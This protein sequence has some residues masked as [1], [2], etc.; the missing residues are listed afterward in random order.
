M[1]RFTIIQV[2]IVLISLFGFTFL[3]AAEENI[4]GEILIQFNNGVNTEKIYSWSENNK[5]IDLQPVRL[6]S[7]RMNVWLFT[8]NSDQKKYT[9]LITSFK[10]NILIKEIQ[11]NHFVTLRETL[12]NDPLFGEQ[13]ALQNTGQN[14]GTADADI[15]ATNAW[16]FVTGGYNALGEEIVIAIIDSGCDLGHDDLDFWKNELEI[17][18]NNIDD[19][20]NGYVDDYDGWNAY[21]HTGQPVSSSHGTHVAGIAGAVGNNSLG[22]SGVNWG[23]KIMPVCG[24]SSSE[25]VVVEAYGYVLEM[26]ARYNETDGAEGAYVVVTNASFGVNNG[27]PANFPIWCAIYDSLGAEGVLSCGATANNNWNID[28]V[29][30]MPTACDSDY[31]ITVTNTTNTDTRNPSAGYGATT[32]D[33]GAPGTSIKSTDTNDS[34]SYKTGTSMATPQVTGAVALMYSAIPANILDAFGNNYSDLAILI[35]NYLLDNVDQIDALADITVSGGRLNVHR[36]IQQFNNRFEVSGTVTEPVIWNESVVYVIDD[37]II[38]STGS[39]TITPG[40]TIIF[41]GPYTLTVEGEIHA[42]GNPDSLITFTV[43]DTTGFS[44]P[45]SNS[46]C[47]KGMTFNNPDTIDTLS[48]CSFN[49]VKQSTS[50]TTLVSCLKINDENSMTINNCIFSHCSGS[51]GSAINTS[52]ANLIISECSFSECNSS[53]E[54]GAIYIANSSEFSLIDC[55]FNNNSA[56]SGGAVY[57]T[58][59]VFLFDHSD[60]SYNQAL[61]DSASGSS[62]CVFSGSG[63]FRDNRFENDHSFA[64]GGSISLEQ[65]L[66]EVILIKNY[67]TNNFAATAGGSLYSMSCPNL[68]LTNNILVNGFSLNGGAAYFSDSAVSAYNNTTFNN[69]SL[70]GGGYYFLNSDSIFVT[71]D[72]I[73]SNNAQN[74]GS[75]IFLDYSNAVINYSDIQGGLEGIYTANDAVVSLEQSMQLNPEFSNDPDH[76]YSLS[77]NSPCKNTGCPDISAFIYLPETDFMENPRL[78]EDIIDIG[79]Y[80]YLY[81]SS[82][83]DIDAFHIPLKNFPNPFNPSTTIEFSL[84]VARE[85]FEDV[86]L[87]IFNIRGQKIYTCNFRNLT[88]GVTKTTWKGEDS[89]GKSVASGVYLYRLSINNEPVSWNKMLLMK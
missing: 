20:E 7:A 72:I 21:N 15:D 52:A 19:D 58:N 34:Y 28:V 12:P 18:G 56:V 9:D 44:L 63:Y 68:T 35:K 36:A 24:S 4:P 10:S 61:S 46:G 71:N 31:L 41:E 81:V 43:A 40:S 45:D 86:T 27:N 54:G 73:F 78:S 1:L 38:S 84:P 89:Q 14:N 50:D 47:W 8:Y 83:E 23:A 82:D 49:Y 13:W 32:I 62:V 55:A 88:N 53:D 37:V 57:L 80:E 3:T 25:S 17:P 33:L 74:S 79:A 30:D 59:S 6:L 64:C 39:V 77:G 85:I 75:Q 26:R 22:V 29:N 70:N 87:D 67:F 2:M 76:H 51:A 66:D 69:F 48:Y 65:C 60:F 5:D 16:D 11:Y 42:N